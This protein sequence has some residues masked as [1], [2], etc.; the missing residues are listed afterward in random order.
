M[1][2]ENLPQEV[3]QFESQEKANMDETEVVN[4]GDE[5]TVKK[6]QIRYYQ[7]L[8][9]EDD[10]EK[11]VQGEWAAKNVKIL[12]YLHCI[13]ELSRKFTRIEFKHVPRAQ[14]EFADALAT[15]SSMIQHSD[16]NYIDSIEVKLFDRHAYCFHVDEELDGR[17]WY[18]DIKTLIEA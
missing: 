17:P 3:E 1:M 11:T 16:K 15:L 18:Y 9:N 8:M 4:L 14:N 2:P 6:T 7:I 13:K 10:A 5:E 12:P